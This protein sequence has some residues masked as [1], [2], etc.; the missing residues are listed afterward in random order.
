MRKFWIYISGFVI[1]MAFFTD[2]YF[3][4][5]FNKNLE[6]LD[7][8][9]QGLVSLKSISIDSTKIFSGVDVSNSIAGIK[10]KRYEFGN[11][12]N[13]KKGIL[14]GIDY[15]ALFYLW[16]DTAA[17]IE[18][19]TRNERESKD[20]FSAF[21]GINSSIPPMI[22]SLELLEKQY[23]EKANF[24]VIIFGVINL[25]VLLSLPIFFIFLQRIAF[26]DLKAKRLALKS[27]LGSL[28]KEVDE[29]ADEIEEISTK[30]IKLSL[31]KSEDG[32]SVITTS[33]EEM[34]KKIDSFLRESF[35][36]ERE[37]VESSLQ[38]LI[39]S[40]SLSLN[41]I[42]ASTM[43]E[44]EKFK[45]LEKNLEK[46]SGKLSFLKKKVAE[47]SQFIKSKEKEI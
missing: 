24:N 23:R 28:N 36:K 15:E 18:I 45:E 25:L 12:L 7:K 43:M 46:I 41:N 35:V 9:R 16:T 8:V 4:F 19:I 34:R 39:D 27:L 1:L 44:M 11:F 38:N 40:L 20:F 17:N 3:F 21:S 13:S 30:T 10:E 31:R 42:I 29:L 2:L 37:G 5:L 22:E 14:K 32:Y 47:I 33:L 6:D 26:S